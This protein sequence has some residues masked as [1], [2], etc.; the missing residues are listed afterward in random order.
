M[1][2]LITIFCLIASTGTGLKAQFGQAQDVLTVET[3]LSVDKIRPGDEFKIGVRATLNNDWH[4]NS[5]KPSEDFLIPTV[6]EFD[7]VAGLEFGEIHYP[8]GEMKSFEFSETPL[9]VYEGSV[10]VWADVKASSA[11]GLG[12]M[13]ISGKFAYQACN[14]LSCLIPTN[15]PFEI[16]SSVV[17]KGSPIEKIN[18]EKFS[19]KSSE[20]GELQGERNG[21]EISKLFAGSGLLLTFGFIFLSGLALNLTPC[22][23]PI[24][25]IT[26]SFFVGQASGK[27]SRSFLLA[28]LYVIGMSV[29]YS[30]LGVIAAMT[31]GLLG[32]S[33]QSPVVLIGIAAIFG[34]FAASMFGAF[35]IKVPAFLS[36]FA[37]GSRQGV[38]GSLFMGLTVG[39]VAAPCIG[40]FVLSLLT[41]VAAKGD[42]LT[43]FLL[44]FVLSM[45]LG[46]PYIFLGTFSSSIKN[47]PKSG[48][49][50]V[51][52]KKV[53]GVI[54]IAVAIYFVNPLLSE[55]VYVVLLTATGVIGGAVVGFFDKSKA[56]FSLFKGL[57]PMIGILMILFGVWTSVSAW[58]ESNVEHFAWQSYVDQLIEQAQEEGKPVLIDFFADW[59][60]PCKQIEKKLFT[61]PAIVA[62]SKDFLTLK[63]DLTKENSEWVKN[64]RMK[65]RVYGVPTIILLDGTGIEVRRFTDELVSFRPEKFQKIMAEVKTVKKKQINPR[66]RIQF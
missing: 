56:S 12:E 17:E 15:K 7:S 38:A 52:V 31:G 55:A 48:E 42:P 45:G 1:K 43:G 63:A 32:S 27:I 61:A 24:I 54:M 5:N 10:V 4:I 50:M 46:L 47:L 9:S 21:N 22:V 64:L 23:Y 28:M 26:V 51:W 30:A 25:P 59:C 36:N 20:L 35:E 66:V 58:A 2:H 62:E 57:K 53:F 6:V 40:P 49:W 65:Y 60:I 13:K 29:T 14:D 39:I 11:I 33:L 34:L 8:N 18:E 3:F 16:L 44:F 19:R 37:G 41:Y